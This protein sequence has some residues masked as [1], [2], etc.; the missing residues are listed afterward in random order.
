MPDP[1]VTPPAP[2]SPVT[3]M[4][5]GD[6]AVVPPVE[7]APASLTPPAPAVPPAPV[8]PEGLP[9]AYWDAA[10]GPKWT[11]LNAALTKLGEFET[12]AAGVPEKPDGYTFDL[13]GDMKLPDGVTIQFD[14]ADPM[15]GPVL[16]EAAGIAHQLGIGQEGFSRL[17]GVYVRGELAADQQMREFSKTSL[18]KL[19]SNSAGRIDAVHRWA[20]SVFG[21]GRSQVIKQ[22]II[23]AEQVEAFES[24]MR[25][26]STQGVVAPAGR[27]DPAG[28]SSESLP[29]ARRL[30]PSMKG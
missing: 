24:A 29:L 25:A 9:D 13:P 5:S 11:D 16:T 21:E 28:Q 19:G 12:R 17:L 15:L 14:P 30:F 18:A 2:V 23:S 6:P 3:P 27:P 7:G 26:F 10:A 8:R 1:T 4:P 22:M 20:D